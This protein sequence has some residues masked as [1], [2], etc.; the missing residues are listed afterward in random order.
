LKFFIKYIS[1]NYVP[2]KLN[3]DTVNKNNSAN[4]YLG[5]PA[6]FGFP[7]FIIVD[8]KGKVLQIQDSSLLEEGKGYNREK[9]LGFFGNWTTKALI[10]SA[11]K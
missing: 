9:V 8:A 1:D 6:R 7:V 4:E 3:Y 2:V 11:K 10:P 5:N